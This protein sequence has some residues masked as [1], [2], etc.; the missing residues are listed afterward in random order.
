[1][2]YD[3]RANGLLVTEQWDNKVTANAVR[4][5]GRTRRL[6]IHAFRRRLNIWRM[7]HGRA[8]DR[9][10][11]GRRVLYGPRKR[12]AEA[13]DLVSFKSLVADKMN[14]TGNKLVDECLLRVT[15]M[16]CVP[17]NRIEYWLRICR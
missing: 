14:A 9:H 17:K 13:L 1:M 12:A 6:R 2:M 4:A 3:D 5:H 10:W 16:Y 8:S 15:E 7:K 11:D